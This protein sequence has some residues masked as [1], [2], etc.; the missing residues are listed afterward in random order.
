MHTRQEP[1]ESGRPATN[2]LLVSLADEFGPVRVVEAAQGHLPD[3]PRSHHPGVVDHHSITIATNET[4]ASNAGDRGTEEIGRY[5]AVTPE[6]LEREGLRAVLRDVYPQPPA[7]IAVES[8]IIESL[9]A[10]EARVVQ[11]TVAVTTSFD[12]D[13]P[14]P[15]ERSESGTGLVDTAAPNWSQIQ[16]TA[17]P[18]IEALELYTPEPVSVTARSRLQVDG[19]LQALAAE[20]GAFDVRELV[21]ELDDSE[22]D[23]FRTR[24]DAGASGGA[25]IWATDEEGRVLLVR[26]EG[27]NSWSEPGGKREA[28]E[29]FREAAI[30]EFSEETGV[31]PTVTDVQEVHVIVHEHATGDEPS[32]VSP[33]VVFAGEATGEPSGREGEIAA[34]EW[35]TT[36]PDELLYPALLDFDIPAS[37]G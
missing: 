30:R 18:E 24:Y 3:H 11:P 33:I 28:G 26:H 8:V 9:D 22:Y 21:W 2:S 4:P 6:D 13:V 1:G 36:H 14:T 29:T 31:D 27:E 5:T 10:R 32:I 17:P 15:S 23:R 34:A 12:S 20:Y 7:S 35:W 37:Q 19:L 16:S 25:G